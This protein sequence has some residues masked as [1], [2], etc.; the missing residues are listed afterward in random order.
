MTKEKAYK[1]LGLET[2]A[3]T[4]NVRKTHIRKTHSRLIKRLHLDRY[5]SSFLATLINEAKDVPL[6]DHN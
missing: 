3:A 1:I 6:S 2:E 5:D 4:T